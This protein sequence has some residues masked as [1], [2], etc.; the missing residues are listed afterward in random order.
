MLTCG[1]QRIRH[2]FYSI[3]IILAGMV[4]ILGCKAKEDDGGGS[5]TNEPP[6]YQPT[7]PRQWDMSLVKHLEAGGLL[8]PNVSAVKGSDG[9]IRIAY[10]SDGT[11]YNTE[12]RYNINFILWDTQTDAIISEETLDPSPPETGGEGLDNCN[13]LAF[14]MNNLNAPVIAYQ[15]GLFRDQAPSDGEQSDVMLSVRGTNSWSEYTG[16]IGYVDRN[17]FYD[18]LAGSDMSMAIDSTGNIHIVFQFY[19]EGMDSYNFEYPALNYVR[20]ER[21]SLGDTISGSEWADREETVYG[22]DFTQTSA[23]HRGVGYGCKLLLDNSGNP[24][25]FFAEF[26]DYSNTYGLWF[27]RRNSNGT[28]SRQWVEQVSN[29]WAIGDISAAKAA[30]GSFA[31][32]YTK[33]CLNCD[34]DEGDHLKYA[35]QSGN[36][37]NVRVV[38]QSSICG[39]SPSLAFDSEGH[40][41]IAYYDKRSYIGRSRKHLKFTQFNGSTWRSETVA[42]DDDYGHYN[43][44]WF[45]ADNVPVICSYSEAKDNIAI[46]RKQE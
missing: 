21:N 40:P 20:H 18:G 44:L 43:S 36:S 33:V 30:D 12:N 25:V 34:D 24:V 39:H 2:T 3:I 42:E 9:D 16:A 15:G 45:D 4:F 5:A 31:V 6:V 23:T 38:D 1:Q 13:P 14:A 28:W 32:A 27:A 26:T 46:F 22:S 7:N 11:D 10:F 37:W 8:T 41:A 35:A 29:G 17:P 19:Y